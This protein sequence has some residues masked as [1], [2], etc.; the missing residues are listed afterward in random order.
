MANFFDQFDQADAAPA[1]PQSGTSTAPAAN[2]FDQFDEQKPM[3]VPAMSLTDRATD[4]GRSAL[5]GLDKG[6]AGIAGLPADAARGISWLK[7]YAD[8]KVTGGNQAD[9]ARTRDASA[10]VPRAALEPYGSDALHQGSGLAYEPQTIAGKYAD[11]VASFAPGAL[12]GPGSVMRRFM[13]GAGVPGAASEAAGQLTAGTAAEPFARV[14]AALAAPTIAARAITPVATSASHIPLTNILEAEGVPLTAGQR[15]GNKPLQYMESVLSETPFAGGGAERAMEAQRQGLN[16]AVAR[17]FGES[18]DMLT[19][20]VMQGAAKRIGGV[21]DEVQNRNSL[22]YDAQMGNDIANVIDRYGKK[23]TSQQRDTFGNLVQDIRD[24]T[25]AGGGSIPGDVYQQARSDMTKL[26]QGAKLT[27][28]LY[29]DSVKGLRNAMDSAFER[30]IAGTDDAGRLGEARRQYAAMKAAEKAV[31]GAGVTAAEGNV[32]PNLLRSAV[33]NQD[34]AAYVRGQGD[35]AD[36]ARAATAV[37]PLPNSGTSPRATAVSLL[38]GLSGLGSGAM[39]GG[40]SPGAVAAAAGGALV[41]AA[42]SRA[43]MSPL[44]Q[45]YLG[46]RL[47]NPE[48]G[49]LLASPAPGLRAVQGYEDSRADPLQVRVRAKR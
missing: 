2:F 4:L 43:I 41:P 13:L 1:A 17:R 36:L 16:A 47:I 34:K 30:S 21:F 20:D 40:M 7:D 46:N 18:A 6:M 12:L 19:P 15:T 27:D 23:F 45:A 37:A 31:G 5:S 48:I 38:T 8:A 49:G 25:I 14:G 22:Q 11:T 33:A 3:S 28:P 10:P 9:I 24:Q 32:S 26:A 35:M 44:G 29:S 39:L 42:V